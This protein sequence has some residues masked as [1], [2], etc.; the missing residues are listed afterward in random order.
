MDTTMTMIDER[1]SRSLTVGSEENPGLLDVRDLCVGFLVNRR[2]IDILDRVT[3]TLDRDEILAVIGETGCGKSVMGSAILHLLPDNAVVG[4]SI[5]FKG[6]ETLRMSDEEFRRLRG[7]GVMSV[8]QN[9]VSSLDPLMRVGD[10]VEEC[11]TRTYHAR[12][13]AGVDRAEAKNRVVRLFDQLRFPDPESTYREY[14]CEMSGGMCQRVLLSMGA[15]TH[16]ELLV[17]D[18]PTKAID[19]SIRRNVMEMLREL[20]SEMRCAMLLITH[21]IPLVRHLADRVAVMYAGTIV[22]IGA[23]E[24]VIDHPRHPYTKGL[25]DSTPE[26]GFKVMKGFM[27]SF[28]HLPEGCRFSDRCPLFEEG[29]C[30][31]EQTL[32]S[33][34]RGWSVRCCKAREDG[35]GH[36]DA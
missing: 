26:R 18:E 3:F 7:G 33:V 1:E 34:D 2:R 5:G 25:I 15:I 32:E 9:P 17:V 16:P 36:R 29:R 28:A 19:W 31:V 13:G 11:I 27:P 12:H 24:E 10:Q 8:A 23:A 20:K 35:G 22:E 30:G 14:P 21:D 6:Q 4:G